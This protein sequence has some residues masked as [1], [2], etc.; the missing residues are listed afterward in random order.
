MYSA[1][2]NTGIFEKGSIYFRKSICEKVTKL[3]LIELE[4]ADVLDEKK[5]AE[6]AVEEDTLCSVFINY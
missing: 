6:N 4:K 3:S 2:V 5:R 1:L